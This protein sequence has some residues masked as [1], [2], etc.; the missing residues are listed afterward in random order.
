MLSLLSDRSQ[1]GVRSAKSGFAKKKVSTITVKRHETT[2]ETSSSFVPIHVKR[3]SSF[4][5]VNTSHGHDRKLQ[6]SAATSRIFRT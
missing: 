2:N 3:V 1:E 4:T 6:G 5:L